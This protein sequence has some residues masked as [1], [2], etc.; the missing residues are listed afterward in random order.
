GH[1]PLFDE[2]VYA[3]IDMRACLDRRTSFGGPTKESVLRQI[4]SVRETLKNYN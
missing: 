4:Q 1:S 2:D 3:A